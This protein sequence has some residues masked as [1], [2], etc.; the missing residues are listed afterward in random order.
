MTP[1]IS[2]LW[3]SSVVLRHRSRGR[4]RTDAA[5][6]PALRRAG[7]VRD[8]RDP[9]LP[10]PQGEHCDEVGLK[11]PAQ[12]HLSR[13]S[14]EGVCGRCALRLHKPQDRYEVLGYV[15]V[16]EGRRAIEEGREVGTRGGAREGLACKRTCR[17]VVCGEGEA[18]QT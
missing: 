10:V 3:L 8:P 15:G 17:G 18:P 4:T 9:F 12:P 7:P 16:A 13:V 2:P 1:R 11:H 14:R 5:D 6:R